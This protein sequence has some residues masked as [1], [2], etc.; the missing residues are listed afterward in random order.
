MRGSLLPSDL[1]GKMINVGEP[2][3]PEI[4]VP[5][6]AIKPCSIAELDE[7]GRIVRRLGNRGLAV[8]TNTVWT[9][10]DHRPRL[11]LTGL[12][13]IAAALLAVSSPAAAGLVIVAVFAMWILEA[14]GFATPLSWASAKRATQDA[15]NRS[16]A[17]NRRSRILLLVRTS[18]PRRRTNLASRLE[19]LAWPAIGLGLVL[20]GVLAGVAAVVESHS[21]DASF[22]STVQALELLPSALFVAAIAVALLGTT[23]RRPWDAIRLSGL[24]PAIEAIQIL[25]RDGGPAPDLLMVGAATEGRDRRVLKAHRDC[26]SACRSWEYESGERIVE[27]LKALS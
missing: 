9:R 27:E 7:F 10:P 14:A 25:E 1:L 4:A 18:S 3:T 21:R 11:I 13:G 26:A 20:L 19:V 16:G 15:F 2:E 17:P 5:P 6:E 24:K 8:M 22:D 12:I 23:K